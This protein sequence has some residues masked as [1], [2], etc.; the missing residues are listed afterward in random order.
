MS[1]TRTHSHGF[2]LFIPPSNGSFVSVGGRS[3]DPPRDL[4]KGTKGS[5]I[6][7]PSSLNSCSPS[8]APT[9]PCGSVFPAHSAHFSS[10]FFVYLILP[11]N[12]AL[13]LCFSYSHRSRPPFCS[14]VPPTAALVPCRGNFSIESRPAMIHPTLNS[15]TCPTCCLD[16]TW[17]YR[18]RV[19][20]KSSQ[21]PW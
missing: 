14:L 21:D 11:R 12:L 7:L 5:F 19:C 18:P 17:G 2:P 6:C 10:C 20:F 15:P 16:L 4:C 3:T 8:L 13:C 1:V 9:A